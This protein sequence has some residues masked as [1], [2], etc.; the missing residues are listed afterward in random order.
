VLRN[1]VARLRGRRRIDGGGR[2]GSPALADVR[3]AYTPDDDGLPDPGE[4][5]W[6]WVPYEE[7]PNQGKDRPV[8]VI[9]SIGG[10]EQRLAVVPVTSHSPEGRNPRDW[11]AIGSGRWDG[12][13]RMSY[14]K[15]TRVLR[16]DAGAVRREGA[17]LARDRFDDVV[18]GVRRRN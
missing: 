4:V 9:G 14:A 5:V 17:T 2:G 7:D 13:G 11:V 16:V 18:A 15:V 10:D 3:I 1:V 6:T 8:V 12:K